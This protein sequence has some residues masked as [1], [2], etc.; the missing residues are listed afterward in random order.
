MHQAGFTDSSHRLLGHRNMQCNGAT[1]SQPVYAVNQFNASVRAYIESY[2]S[3]TADAWD[4]VL[5]DETS[6]TVSTQFY[7]PGAG[8]CPDNANF[9]LCIATQEYPNDAA[10]IQAHQTLFSQLTH[11]NGGT[12]KLFFNGITM[13]NGIATDLGL[14]KS[15]NMLGGICEDC[16]VSLGTYHADRYASVLNAMA[17]INAM[18][19]GAF[20]EENIG[21]WPAGSAD[22]IAVRTTTVA[23]A[24]LGYS[25]G[26]TIV[27]PDLEYRSHDL[28][29]WPEYNIV[30]TQPVE[31]MTSSYAQIQVAT[32]VY[33]REFQSCYNFG[34]P[35]GQCAAIVNGN[36]SGSVT[37]SPSWLKLAYGHVIQLSGGDIHSGGRILLNSATFVPA[38]TT[39]PAGHAVLLAR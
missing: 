30:P 22:Q 3:S 32:R 24:W 12:W 4:Y 1:V 35:M 7:G 2:L 29:V 23:M 36:S 5:M 9:H 26:H 17:E 38:A 8:M 25:P 16:V 39:I 27:F 28:G 15:S 20:I 31:S 21:D 34:V 6:G 19:N 33:A 10:V 18:P 14:F 13:N 11:S 37:V